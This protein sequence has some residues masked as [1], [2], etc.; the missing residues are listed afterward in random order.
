VSGGKLEFEKLT[1]V[2]IG[3][4]INVQR[5]L[6]PGL[7]ESTYHACFTYELRKAGLKVQTEVYV[8]IQYEELLVEKA[9]RMD[10]LVEGSVVLELKTAER[11]TDAHEAQLFTYLR[12]SGLPLGILL[13]FWAW[14][15]KK[16]GIKR[17]LNPRSTLRSPPAFLRSPPAFLR[18]PPR[19]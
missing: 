5:A 19:L 13:N 10:I 1:G 18:S 16:A 12:F 9:Y 6:G 11:L 14:P 4:A 17:V 7:L 8:D 2:I 3:C 15:L